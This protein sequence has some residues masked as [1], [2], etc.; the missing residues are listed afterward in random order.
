MASTAEMVRAVRE[1]ANANYKKDG[2]DFLVECWDDEDII[3]Q[4]AGAKTVAGAI[5]N[6][7][8]TLKLLHERRQEV[9]NMTKW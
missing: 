3:E 9:Q 7:A 2:W 5:R 1:H 6:C 8:K 4:I